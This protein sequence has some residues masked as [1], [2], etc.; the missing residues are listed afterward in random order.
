MMPGC[1]PFSFDGG[2]IGVLVLHGF[3]GNPL[4]MRGVADRMANA[5]MS[6][7]MPL[8]P[9]HGTSLEDMAPTR[10]SDWSSAAENAFELLAARSERVVVFGLSMGGLLTCWLAERKPEIA[11]IV[12]VNPLVES[13]G[14]EMV[15]SI[16]ELLESGIEVIDSIGSDIA[17]P[18]ITEASYP[19][20][21]LACLLSLFEGVNEVSGKLGSITC[22]VLL[23]S[24]TQD[25]VV[26]PSNGTHLM[27]HVQGPVEQVVLEK[28]F[29]VATL[30]FDAA[31]IEDESL[32]FIE[33]L[34]AER[35]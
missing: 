32:A 14:D 15:K 4:S 30:D 16:Q 35:F 34:G 17:K 26:P 31:L 11:G 23:F 27:N 20:T 7:E 8:L 2:P 13:I 18:G 12:L 19:G 6:V 33:R 28:S 9:G 10:F 29:H 3:T 5:G 25:H 21:P 24:S 22:P 1:E